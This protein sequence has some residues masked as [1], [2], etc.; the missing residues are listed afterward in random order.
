MNK[1]T[2]KK[3]QNKS[4]VEMPLVNPYAA[5]IDI[6][7]TE[8]VVAVPPGADE[9]RVSNALL[10]QLHWRVQAFTGNHYSACLYVMDSKFTSLTQ[11]M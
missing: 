1:K 10:K 7:D 11:S 4:I 2:S 8:H 5:G 6:S 3:V 9:L